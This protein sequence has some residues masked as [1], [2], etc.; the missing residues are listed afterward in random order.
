ME[1][2][3]RTGRSGRRRERRAA[4][5]CDNKSGIDPLTQ[6]STHV[7][8]LGRG[9]LRWRRFL[10]GTW[11]NRRRGRHAGTAG[12][13]VRSGV[14]ELGIMNL[15][16]T[17]STSNGDAHLTDLGRGGSRSTLFAHTGRGAGAP[18]ASIPRHA[19]SYGR[20]RRRASQWTRHLTVTRRRSAANQLSPGYCRWSFRMVWRPRRDSNPCFS[21]ER[22]TSWASGRR[23][24]WREGG[25]P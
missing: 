16:S 3:P 19:T 7:R 14:G 10:F 24:P 5:R 11:R 18:R 6:T 21:L 25:W 8:G 20:S 9:I 23:G 15:L 17:Q 2:S 22:A 1:R 13:R 12:T 4:P